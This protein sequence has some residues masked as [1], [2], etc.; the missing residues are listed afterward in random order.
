[1]E[2]KKQYSDTM[3]KSTSD[4]LDKP[5]PAALN[6]L[7]LNNITTLLSDAIGEIKELR[8]EIEKLKEKV[9]S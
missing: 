4:Y 9:G 8:H 2:E 7:L 6:R 1:M 3:T 5:L